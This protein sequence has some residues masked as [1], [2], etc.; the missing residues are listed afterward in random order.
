MPRARATARAHAPSKGRA[1]GD[2]RMA[3]A[4]ADQSDYALF[5]GSGVPGARWSKQNAPAENV[6][7]ARVGRAIHARTITLREVKLRLTAGHGSHTL[8]RSSFYEWP[9]YLQADRDRKRI[10]FRDTRTTNHRRALTDWPTP[11]GLKGKS[12]R[13][14]SKPASTRLKSTDDLRVSAR[15]YQQQVIEAVEQC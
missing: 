13:R 15:P 12:W 3:D 9:S 5:C 11:D 6:S 14:T 10:W 8:F 1:A 2:C 7:A 4:K